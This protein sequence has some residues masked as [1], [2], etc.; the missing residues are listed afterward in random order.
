M[1]QMLQQHNCLQPRFYCIIKNLMMWELNTFLNLSLPSRTVPLVLIWYIMWLLSLPVCKLWCSSPF[2][3]FR[4]DVEN[5][6]GVGENSTLITILIC[7]L[8]QNWWDPYLSKL[9]RH[10]SVQPM[11]QRPHCEQLKWSSRQ[12]HSF[13]I[14]LSGQCGFSLGTMS[15]KRRVRQIFFG[16]ISLFPCLCDLVLSIHVPPGKC[17][18]DEK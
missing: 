2:N 13:H 16:W 3:D 8:S 15:G 4:A 7:I 9:H 14:E 5:K 18:M 11:T 6:M 12:V 10:D 17:E 1:L